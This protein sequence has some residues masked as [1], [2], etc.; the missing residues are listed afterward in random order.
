[1]GDRIYLSALAEVQRLIGVTGLLYLSMYH[2]EVFD[3]TEHRLLGQETRKPA[4]RGTH[5]NVQCRLYLSMLVKAQLQTTTR[6]N[7]ALHKNLGG[8]TT[9]VMRVLQVYK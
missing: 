6:V 8:I 9:E 5:I 7:E 1:M 3:H 2:R 4:N